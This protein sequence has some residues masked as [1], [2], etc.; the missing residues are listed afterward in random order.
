MNTLSGSIAFVTGATGFLGG[1]LAHRL[2]AEGAQVR[3][4]AR[5]AHKADFLRGADN[6]SIVSG[7]VTDASRMREL[8][9][10]CD[11]VFHCAAAFG[12]PKQQEQVNVGG[13]RHLM[14]A[15]AEAQVR[16]V[17]F[18]SSIAAYGYAT[19]GLLREDE[20]L[21]P[22]LREAYSRT[23]A[24]AES[25]VRQIGEQQH[26]SYAI[27]RPGMVYGPRAGQ[28]TDRTFRLARHRPVLWIG[29]GSGSTFPIHVDDV[30]DLMLVTAVHPAAHNQIFNA[31]HPDP[32]T[33]REFLL[34]YAQLAGHQS[35]LGI[36]PAVAD[37]LAR[38]V[39]V[40]SLPGSRASAAPDVIRALYSQRRIDMTK[41]RDLL[42]WEPKIDLKTGIQSCVPYLQAK[43]WLN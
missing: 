22:T 4:L 14:Q 7:D 21:T 12:G 9:V 28:W 10:G 34:S 24:E 31:V 19:Q 5:S 1:A 3:A 17:I 25:I 35:W 13:T 15:A 6:I 39:A 30:A 16:R 23:K 40:L 33:W 2:A 8:T 18:V 27:L 20:P 37:V 26:L 43:G 42:G 41:A 29:D 36:P 11:F 38:V 32:V